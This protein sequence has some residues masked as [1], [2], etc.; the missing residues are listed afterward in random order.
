MDGLGFDVVTGGG[1]NLEFVVSVSYIFELLSDVLVR[2]RLAVDIGVGALAGV[3]TNVS[4]VVMTA[5]KC[6]MKEDL[7]CSGD[8]GWRSL[9]LDNCSRAL[10]AR[11]PSD[12]V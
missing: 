8:F 4:S 3:N 9:T 12:H 6:P 7:S 1:V 10:H 11:M 5:V 2:V